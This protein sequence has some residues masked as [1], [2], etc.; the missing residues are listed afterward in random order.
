MSETEVS[1]VIPVF[2]DR[3]ALET[4]LPGSLSALGEITPAFELIIAEDG[5]TDGTAEFCTGA[6]SGRPQDPAPPLRRTPRP[7]EGPH[8]GFLGGE[9]GIV[10][11]YDVDLATD[12]AYLAELI[13]AIREDPISRRGPGSSRQ[14]P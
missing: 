13:G 8:P 14:V 11:Y 10:C 6:G 5:S 3:I 2:N 7:G 9:G 4:A 12:L 1:A